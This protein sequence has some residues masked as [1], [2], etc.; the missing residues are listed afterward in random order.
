M[1]DG[2][3]DPPAAGAIREKRTAVQP[4]VAAQTTETTPENV[5]GPGAA[6][7]RIA[8]SF[9]PR[10][11]AAGGGRERPEWTVAPAPP[12]ASSPPSTSRGAAQDHDLEQRSR[13][14][15]RRIHRTGCSPSRNPGTWLPKSRAASGNS[16][17]RG[18]TRTPCLWEPPPTD[19]LSCLV[20]AACCEPYS[21]FRTWIGDI[22]PPLPFETG[23]RQ[24]SIRWSPAFPGSSLSPVSLVIAEHPRLA[25]ALQGAANFRQS[26]T[27][28]ARRYGSPGTPRPHAHRRPV[29]AARHAS[30]MHTWKPDVCP[31]CRR[32]PRTVRRAVSSRFGVAVR[33]TATEEGRHDVDWTRAHVWC[34]MRTVRV[35]GPSPHRAG[36]PVG[37]VFRVM[38]RLR[39]WGPPRNAPAPV[40]RD[41][42]CLPVGHQTLVR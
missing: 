7:R 22:G 38:R 4:E 33:E 35:A 42:S 14:A 34:R 6:T 8:S 29:P 18:T 24:A 32:S 25:C 28:S 10:R 19:R 2:S 31:A 5:T 11:R 39:S 26:R 37:S 41:Q 36:R 27:C 40:P 23:P 3:N 16:G 30:R 1:I 15:R 9:G 21:L 17:S 20:C 12:S 13:G